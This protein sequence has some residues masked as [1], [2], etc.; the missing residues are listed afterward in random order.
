MSV[1]LEIYQQKKP[2]AHVLLVRCY[3]N[4]DII[5]TSSTEGGE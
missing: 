3:R 2:K 1:I 4:A 5:D